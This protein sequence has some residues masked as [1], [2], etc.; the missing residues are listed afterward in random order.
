MHV[1]APQRFQKDPVSLEKLSDITLAG[2]ALGTESEDIRNHPFQVE[3][4]DN[5]LFVIEHDQ[6]YNHLLPQ[7]SSIKQGKGRGALFLGRCL[8]YLLAG[9]RGAYPKGTLIWEEALI[10]GFTVLILS[11]NSIV[12]AKWL[13]ARS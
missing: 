13:D 9:R 10:G 3:W 5:H 1:S 8:F 11:W 2:W 4:V 7:H 12:T 6:N